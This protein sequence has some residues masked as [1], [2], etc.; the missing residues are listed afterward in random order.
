MRSCGR[1]GHYVGLS[2]G[3]EMPKKV[4]A[5]TAARTRFGRD[6]LTKGMPVELTQ[7]VVNNAIQKLIPNGTVGHMRPGWQENRLKRVEILHCQQPSSTLSESEPKRI[8]EISDK[9]ESSKAEQL[10]SRPWEDSV[11][12]AEEAS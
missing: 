10:L 11:E 1:I 5:V 12:A 9:L 7:R 3:Q 2:I 4:T 8:K 6:S